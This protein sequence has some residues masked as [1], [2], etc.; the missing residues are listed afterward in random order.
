MVMTFLSGSL[1][2]M[3]ICDNGIDDDGDGYIDCYDSDCSGDPSCGNS[4]I[5]L[6]TPICQFNPPATPFTMVEKWRTNSTFAPMDNRQTPVIG[7]IDNDGT[8]EVI[9]KTW[10]VANALYV[11]DGSTGALELTINAPVFELFNDAP[12]IGDVDNDGFGEIIVVSDGTLSNRSLYCYEHNGALKWISNV[13]VGYNVND[14]RWVPG[15][16]DFDQDG[17]PEIYI[18]NQIFN[19]QTGAFLGSGGLGGSVG[20]APSSINEAFS[21]AADVLPDA[22][23]PNCA[24]LE[25]ICGNTV[26]AVNPA[27]LSVTPAITMPGISDGPASL[28]DIDLDGDLDAVVIGRVGF[29]GTIFVWDIQT[30]TLIAPPFQIDN[31]SANMPF[32]TGTTTGGHANIGDFNNDG[33]PEIGLAGRNIYVVV[34][35]NPATSTLVELWS[36][37]TQDNSE[38]T[39]SSVFDFEGDGAYEVVYRDETTLYVYDG[40][41]G[42][43]KISVPCQASTRYD[44]PVITD[45]DADGQTDIVC[46]C[47]DY[48][49]TY[50]STSNPWVKAR[51][52]WNQHSYFVVNVNDDLSI[53][54]VQQDHQA[55][56]PPSSPTAFPFNSFL[57]QTTQLDS[58]G[59]PI[60]AASD[61]SIA[62]VNPLTHINYNPCQNGINDSIRV[63]FT[64]FN[65]GSEI[66]PAG[67]P[68][69]FYQNNPFLA[70]S[71]FL[72]GTTVSGNVAPGTP[73]LLPPASI[74]DQGGT[75]DLFVLINDSGTTAPPLTG[76]TANHVECDFTNNLFQFTIV[77][78]GNLPPQI[79]TVGVPT[80]TVFFT[81]PENA[82]STLCLG[83][84]DPNGDNF[85]VTALLSPPSTGTVGGLSSGDTCITFAA[86]FAQSGQF[87]FT[88]EICDNANVS[89]CDTVVIVVNVF[90]V[91]EPPVAVFDSVNTPEDT[92]INIVVQVNDTDPDLDSL[93]TNTVFGGPSNGTTTI[94]PSG[95]VTYTPDTN[96]TGLDSFFYVI[97]DQGILPVFCDTA[98]VVVNVSPVNDLPI[99][100]SDAAIVPNDTSVVIAVLPND[101]DIEGDAGLA[102]VVACGVTSGTA[103]VQGDS[104]LY[105]ANPA[106]LGLDSFCYTICDAQGCDTGVVYVTVTDGNVGPIANDDI[107][108]TTHNDPVD[109]PVLFNDTDVDGNPLITSQVLCPPANGIATIL[110]N[111]DIQY[112]PDSGFLG[113]D[114][115]CYVV[116]DS[117]LAGLSLCDTAFVYLDVVSDNLPPVV[118]DDFDTI[119]H[120]DPITVIPTGNDT[121][122]NG[123]QLLTLT[124]TC[125]PTNGVI[126]NDT[127]TGMITYTPDSGFLGLDT[128]C[129]NI[130]DNGV[131]IFC[132]SGIVVIQVISDN[133]P[134]MA[135]DDTVSS[136]AGIAATRDV[137]VNDLDPD[138][139]TL[140]TTILQSP[141]NGSALLNGS[142]ITYSPVPGFNGI[143]SLLYEICDNGV[144]PLCDTAW[145][146]YII[147]S[148]DI[149]PPVGFSPNGDGDNETWV[150]DGLV[151][152]P[153]NKVT[154]F[155]RWGNTVL[156]TERYQ[157]DWD[158][159]WEGKPLPE[160]T[161]YWVI[162]PGDGS[163]LVKGFVVLFR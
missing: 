40:A 32:V 21:V 103:V 100:V 22:F 70:G 143:D 31:V 112:L 4:Y 138:G 159:T 123:G 30:A 133:L 49:I 77:N 134:P 152:Y 124:V 34:D 128:F 88:V 14:D 116:C 15:I 37:T 8:P 50:Q 17:N 85:D 106:F 69:S 7:D 36:N 160:G 53:P 98:L 76:P 105:T 92:P 10:G 20:S 127:V 41:T 137:L 89:L 150:I 79:D 120:A 153:D 78:C 72:G 155:N 157:N 75:F 94:N 62:I 145:V 52:V 13:P 82:T 1:F 28:A 125:L 110:A 107:S 25:L 136:V 23:C 139:N 158:G 9:A 154:I 101:I 64:V 42:A 65:N 43:V 162:D 35:Y 129:Y 109:I 163:E 149:D 97:C 151:A 57:T 66:L 58:N 113:L 61:D 24:G 84:T 146:I 68:I 87:P 51:E 141:S 16:A 11:F 33:T 122:P 161:Y 12:A 104:I 95:T 91:N 18:G 47:A 44:Y 148:S 38:R 27:T 81:I 29:I 119:T 5:N 131:P 117:P 108:G 45:V 54:Q 86:A 56:Y 39:G 99:A 80:D 140:T 115:L 55:G 130:C 121:D 26:Y 90:L 147:G 93:V 135:A 19:G 71:T 83:G 96:F 118:A 156:E 3:E 46:S 63:Q 126:V 73:L 132:D 48:I 67:T 102:A 111:G 59:L 74:P 60:F 144:P 6:P 2:A 142:I 114:T